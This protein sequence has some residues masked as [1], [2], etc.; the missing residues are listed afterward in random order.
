VVRLLGATPGGDNQMPW[1]TQTLAQI[2]AGEQRPGHL[3]TAPALGVAARRRRVRL[4][5]G[6][7]DVAAADALRAVAPRAL[8]T[9]RWGL[10][11]AQQ[12]VRVP[13]PGEAVEGAA[14]P[15]TVG[16]RRWGL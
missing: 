13:R 7:D 4:E 14:D 12:V 10:K 8:A 1:N 3:V 16:A 6:L 11:C 5:H 15:R 9:G 2:V